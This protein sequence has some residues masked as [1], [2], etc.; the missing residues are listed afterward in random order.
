MVEPQPAR[1]LQPAGA[2]VVDQLQHESVGVQE[3]VN[4]QDL[5]QSAGVPGEYDL[6]TVTHKHV[7]VTRLP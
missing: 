1:V 5:A 3:E 2:G 6:V 4:G 7:T